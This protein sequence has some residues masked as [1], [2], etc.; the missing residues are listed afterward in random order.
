[1]HLKHYRV[2]GR[3]TRLPLKFEI[4]LKDVPSSRTGVNSE[5]VEELW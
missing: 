2:F 4:M 1:M 5:Y 3:Y